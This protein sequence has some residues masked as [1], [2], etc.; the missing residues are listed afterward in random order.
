MTHPP[1][2]RPEGTSRCPGSRGVRGCPWPT[3][4]TAS[5]SIRCAV[6]VPSPGPRGKSLPFAVQLCNTS[7]VVGTAAAAVSCKCRI[8][9]TCVDSAPPSLY[10]AYWYTPLCRL[11]HPLL[12]AQPS[13]AMMCC[14]CWQ[15]TPTA[16]HRLLV[17]HCALHP[18][19]SAQLL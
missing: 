5:H 12:S 2:L 17:P 10:T 4:A 8:V 14:L 3:Q 9:C 13:H 7:T 11:L 18:L 6:L 1:D 16:V 15:C 19:L